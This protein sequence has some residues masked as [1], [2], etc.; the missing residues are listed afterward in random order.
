MSFK[1]TYSTEDRIVKAKV[2]LYREFP[3][4]SYIVQ[5]MGMTQDDAI[6]SA[7]V[8]NTGKF[9]YSGPWVDKLANEEVMGVM[10]HEVLHLC[11][12]HPKRMGGRDLVLE[13]ELPP[14]RKQYYSDAVR[15]AEKLP[16]DK[17]SAAMG[18]LQRQQYMETHVTLWNLAI[19]IVVNNIVLMNNLRIPAGTIQP[20]ND[21]VTI[22]GCT[23]DNISDKCAEEIYEELKASLREK[24][25]GK[26]KGEGKGDGE[27]IKVSGSSSEA[28]GFDEH[29]FDE[30]DGEGD[31][32][33]GNGNNP[34]EGKD[35]GNGKS[36]EKKIDWKKKLS[37][38]HAYSKQR[39]AEP[40]GFQREFEVLYKPVLPW[41]SLLR[42]AIASRIPSDVTWSHP[43]RKY[44]GQGFYLPATTGEQ[45]RILIGIDTSGS[46]GQEELSEFMTEVFAIARSFNM[47]E[48]RLITHDA[49]VH[50][51]IHIYNGA[52]HKL[53]K[54]QLHGGG[55]T[56]HRPLYDFIKEKK[57]NRNAKLLVSF[58]DGY[59]DFPEKRPD[60]DTIFVLAGNHCGISHMPTWGKCVEVKQ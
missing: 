15:K 6:P 8:T 14:D 9:L 16:E 5:C 3:F 13:F 32:Q 51:D 34:K 40:A 43:S 56:S 2:K 28:N 21:S 18:F 29:R 11:F 53:K 19:D 10:A 42:K 1:T 4:F 52:V 39:G 26:G 57:Y 46:I 33:E 25:K 54:T 44:I 12:E 50:D 41:R 38:A 37:E 59:S 23:V 35:S 60:V 45:I 24:S 7:A 49:Q 27:T 55:G 17:K 48:F 20:S 31:P 47:V 58:T 22:L 36:S 30:G